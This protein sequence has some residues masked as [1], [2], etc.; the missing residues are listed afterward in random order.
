MGRFWPSFDGPSSQEKNN[1]FWDES[2]HEFEAY[3]TDL[4]LEE[5]ASWQIVELYRKRADAE[6]VFDELKKQWGF[7]GF[8]SRKLAV[9]ELAARLLLLVYNL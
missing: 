7:S 9:S 6:N 4:L 1:I 3:V 2:R 5:A 8:C